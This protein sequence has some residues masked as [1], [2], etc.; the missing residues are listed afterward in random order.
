MIY[1]FRAWATCVRLKSKMVDEASP[2]FSFA[3]VNDLLHTK[4]PHSQGTSLKD[5]KMNIYNKVYLEFIA[6]TDEVEKKDSSS[7]S[8][9]ENA[10]ESDQTKALTKDE[11]ECI[12][13]NQ[14]LRILR[15]CFQ[16]LKL[17]NIAL[18]GK[19]DSLEEE[20]QECKKNH[21]IANLAL[22]SL[23]EKWS[24]LKKR[25]KR[26]KISCKSMKEDLIMHHAALKSTSEELKNLKDEKYLLLKDL[27]EVKTK[28]DLE[29]VKNK[30]LEAR[31]DEKDRQNMD[32]LQHCA[33]VTRQQCKLDETRL[34][35]EIYQLKEELKKEKQENR[36]N[37]N[38]LENLRNHFANVR[39]NEQNTGSDAILSAAEIDFT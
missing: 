2:K 31:L 10:D 19:V 12:W 32:A 5:S 1:I 9:A 37:R 36:L 22:T 39:V 13:S 21:R 15:K 14:E 23:K 8:S 38:A 4:G 29:T 24:E 30:D 35:K 26:I 27:K 6:K 34:R 33:F 11:D 7:S 25:Y 18:V 16:R 17:Q 3:T 28:L 20:L